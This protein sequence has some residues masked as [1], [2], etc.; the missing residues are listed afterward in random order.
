MS[1][2]KYVA[3][4]AKIAAARKETLFLLRRVDEELTHYPNVER[5]RV[6]RDEVKAAFNHLTN[7]ERHHQR[8]RVAAEINAE[9]G[10][11]RKGDPSGAVV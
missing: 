3:G 8:I 11:G 5:L 10:E 4:R 7:A 1:N 9:S 6:M 2:R